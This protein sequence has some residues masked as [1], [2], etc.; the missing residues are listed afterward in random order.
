[1]GSNRSC[2]LSCGDRRR[3]ELCHRCAGG[4][5]RGS[6][7]TVLDRF[8]AVNRTIQGRSENTQ[9]FRFRSFFVTVVASIVAVDVATSLDNVLAIISA[10]KGNMFDVG[11]GIL[12]SIPVILRGSERIARFLERF[13]QLIRIGGVVLT[14]VA[15][16]TLTSDPWIQSW[17]ANHQIRD[18][19]GV[20]ILLTLVCCGVAW[21]WSKMRELH[22]ARNRSLPP[23]P[24]GSK[25]LIP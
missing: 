8:K 23:P 6:Y 21:F 22:I 15:G 25:R 16:Q 11:V 17:L 1:M 9:V 7:I 12:V 5:G 13:P 24:I 14:W 4:Q 18:Y 19:R 3:G 20:E 2:V 10:A